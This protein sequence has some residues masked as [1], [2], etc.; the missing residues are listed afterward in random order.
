MLAHAEL[1]TV[2][3]ELQRLAQT[4]VSPAR[5]MNEGEKLWDAC[6]QALGRTAR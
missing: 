5:L 1:T 2:M 3:Q 4:A 6:Q